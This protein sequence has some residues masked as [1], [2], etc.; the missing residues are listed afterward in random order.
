MR[1]RL[2]EYDFTKFPKLN[3]H[4]I[5]MVDEMLAVDISRLTKM[6][7]REEE[8][9]KDRRIKGGAF[10]FTDED[11]FST[12]RDLRKPAAGSS[13]AN[14]SWIVAQDSARYDSVFEKLGPSSEGKVSGMYIV[15]CMRDPFSAQVC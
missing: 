13:M 7:P 1:E 5:D 9:T 14:E 3:P 8:A 12:K 11:P 2:G 10:G 6:L 15:K 4:L